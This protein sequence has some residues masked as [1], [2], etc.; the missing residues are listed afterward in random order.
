[1][2]LRHLKYFV[3]V[4]EE[5]NFN[6]AAERLMMTQPPLTEHIH[7][8]ED[9]LGIALFNRTKRKVELTPAGELFLERARSLL[10]EAAQCV[11]EVREAVSNERQRLVVGL[12]GFVF[13]RLVSEIMQEFHE[14]YPEVELSVQELDL[15]PNQ[16]LQPLREQL[17]DLIFMSEQNIRDQNIKFERL[18]QTSL[19]VV[20]PSEHRLAKLPRLSLATLANEPT[21]FTLANLQSEVSV[22]LKRAGKPGSKFNL[23]VTQMATALNLVQAGM[24]IA[25]LP[26]SVRNMNYQGVV[27]KPL[28]D[29]SL[30]TRLNLVWRNNDNSEVLQSFLEIAREVTQ[31]RSEATT[32]VR[33]IPQVAAV[34]VAS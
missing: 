2:E 32:K 27:Y 15:P 10:D 22:E 6:R 13:S 4:A 7:H 23:Q 28:A 12:P 16:L 31:S 18:E 26:V 33:S 5:L 24:G 3:T 19:T 20:L 21:I 29:L 8:L 34:G 17:V 1:M 11:L 14:W 9:E 30:L 25:L